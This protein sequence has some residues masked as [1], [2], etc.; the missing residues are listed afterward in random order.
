[1]SSTPPEEPAVHE[2]TVLPPGEDDAAR[3]RAEQ[4]ATRE[5][6]G[7]TVEQLAAKLDV[8]QR[9]REKA[10]ELTSQLTTQAKS[11][12]A[13]ARKQAVT[14]AEAL[15]GTLAGGAADARQKAITAGKAAPDTTRRAAAKGTVAAREH[16]IQLSATGAGLLVAIIFL[17]IWQRSRR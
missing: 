7:A 14:R 2:G 4:D 9:A 10:T 6:L 17:I 11:V 3:L 16:R 5:H 13:Q 15:R 1:M 8:K 12:T